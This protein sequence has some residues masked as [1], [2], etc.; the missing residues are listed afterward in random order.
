M[1]SLHTFF[2][3]ENICHIVDPEYSENIKRK[4]TLFAGA[5]KTELT[6]NCE[7][8]ICQAGLAIKV[9]AMLSQ[10]ELTEHGV[11]LLSIG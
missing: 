4:D 5:R 6:L 7:I 1:G 3:S 8:G 11:F 10:S 9:N 2:L